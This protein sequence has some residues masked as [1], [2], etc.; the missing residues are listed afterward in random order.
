VF[1]LRPET[2][3]SSYLRAKGKRYHKEG[4]SA[5]IQQHFSRHKRP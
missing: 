2:V 5:A 3:G 4:T 1:E